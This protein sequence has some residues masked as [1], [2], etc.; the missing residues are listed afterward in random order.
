MRIMYILQIILR[1]S[2]NI[3][4]VI[5]KI[6][7]ERDTIKKII[8]IILFW[9]KIETLLELNKSLTLLKSSLRLI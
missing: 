7:I 5:I 9:E 8:L 2:L 1:Y 4:T 6:Q 3:K